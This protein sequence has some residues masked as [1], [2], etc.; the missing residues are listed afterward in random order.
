MTREITSFPYHDRSEWFTSS[1][2]NA[3]GSC[4]EARFT[5]GA[6]QVRDSKDRRQDSPVVEFHL[7]A[8]SFFLDA[9]KPKIYRC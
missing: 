4:V 3:G 2:S 9:V 8:W 1:H 5:P 6:T 7:A